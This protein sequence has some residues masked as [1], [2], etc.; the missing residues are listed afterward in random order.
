MPLLYTVYIR[1][2]S[3]PTGLLLEIYFLK[4]IADFWALGPGLICVFLSTSCQKAERNIPNLEIFK[5][6]QPPIILLPRT[7]VY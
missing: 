2:T 3:M 4:L 1:T 5:D 7:A 6:L